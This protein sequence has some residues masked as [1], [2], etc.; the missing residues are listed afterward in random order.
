MRYGKTTVYIVCVWLCVCC[1]A[2]QKPKVFNQKKACPGRLTL[3]QGINRWKWIP[4]KQWVTIDKVIKNNH[5]CLEEA[6]KVFVANYEIALKNRRLA[7]KHRQT[8]VT[9]WLIAIIEF[10]LI[11]AV[12]L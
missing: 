5:A 1:S 3:P 4:R 8:A 10:V 6:R 11:V 7:Q 12:A 2:G 9:G